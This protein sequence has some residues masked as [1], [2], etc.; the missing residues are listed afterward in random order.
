[1]VGVSTIPAIILLHT[2]WR[3][4]SPFRLEIT[5]PVGWELNTNN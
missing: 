2:H 3:S 4:P 1:M 5:V